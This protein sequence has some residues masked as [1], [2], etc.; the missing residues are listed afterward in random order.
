MRLDHCSG[1]A[2]M[3]TLAK[4]DFPV[5]DIRQLLEPGPV[6]LV[7]SAWKGR[8]NIIT[9]GW[10]TVI[11]FSPSLVGCVIA[12]NNVSFEM[13]RKSRECVINV[14]AADLVDKVVGIGNC[15]GD[16]VD[17]FERFRLTPV[18]GAKVAAP[19]VRECFAN[20]ECR[21][22]DARLVK[23]YNFFILEV[24]KA[25]VATSPKYPRTLHYRGK[26]IFLT[27]GQVVNKRQKFTK[28][29]NAPNF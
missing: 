9:M 4:R 1:S 26:G 15:S 6:V 2:R 7:S 20:L 8:N 23:V 28:W 17:K 13:I 18:P 19:L 21:V 5:S 25:H 3:K 27:S 12:D 14:P 22:A 10:H 24:L 16:E 29:K 11:E